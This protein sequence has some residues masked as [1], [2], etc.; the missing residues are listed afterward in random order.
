MLFY[1]HFLSENYLYF[2]KLVRLCDSVI[3]ICFIC[4]EHS[5]HGTGLGMIEGRNQLFYIRFVSLFC[6]FISEKYL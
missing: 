3:Y 1:F 4:V 6:V 5:P 2:K